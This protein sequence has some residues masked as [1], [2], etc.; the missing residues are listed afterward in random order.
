MKSLRLRRLISLRLQRSTFRPLRM[1]R[2]AR[3]AVLLLHASENRG[4]RLALDGPDPCSVI[5]Q[6]ERPLVAIAGHLLNKTDVKI[7]SYG[8]SAFDQ[9]LEA[10]PA[11]TVELDADRSRLMVTPSVP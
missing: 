4:G 6:R 8:Y 7:P 9:S 5:G 3:P 11:L 1:V 2:K 10:Q